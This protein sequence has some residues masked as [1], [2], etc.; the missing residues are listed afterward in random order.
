MGARCSRTDDRDRGFTLVEVIIAMF[1]TLAVLTALIFTLVSTLRV[2]AQAKERQTATAL[3]T[4]VLERM[5]ALPAS[6]VTQVE[7]EVATASYATQVSASVYR[8]QPADLLDGVDEVLI[9]NTAPADVVAS[10][11]P[12]SAQQFDETVEDTTYTIESFVSYPDGVSGATE[13][14]NL[15]A[16]VSWTSRLF[17]EGSTVVQRSTLFTG[18]DCLAGGTSPY[19]APCQGFFTAK[20]GV[21]A[22]GITVSEPFAPP[23]DPTAEDPVTPEAVSLLF[24]GLGSDLSLEQTAAGSSR[25]ASSDAQSVT[26]AVDS[27]PSSEA[28]QSQTVSL[29][30]PGTTTTALGFT[31]TGFGSTGEAR[32]DIQADG[33]DCVSALS[34]GNLTTG[35]ATE[36]RP[37]TSAY[38]Q[39]TSGASLT[40]TVGGTTI[41]LAAIGSGTRDK[42]V[43]GILAAPNP[44]AA[45]VLNAS[46]TC[47]HGAVSR[48]LGTVALATGGSGPVNWD[49]LKGLV[50][51]TGLTET[52]SAEEGVGASPPLYTRAGAL[53]V[54]DGDSYEPIDLSTT[55]DPADPER[56]LSI[57]PTV[58]TYPGSV[59]VTYSGKVTVTPPAAGR[60]GPADCQ[61][62]ACVTDIS[63]TSMVTAALVVT[64]DDGASVS[65]F[66]MAVDLG[67]L[68][69]R[70]SY[71][72]GTDA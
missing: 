1:I 2:I 45:C 72:V 18:G 7:A 70:A 4:Q 16:I 60:S 13:I 24:T 71:K 15:T 41:P 3:A 22:G 68:L 67:G 6:T 51:V 61:T 35:P 30:R 8:L 44:T 57:A 20:A 14:Y 10:G 38:A 36:L 23:S 19:A 29:T 50:S 49:P 17:P 40:Y 48:S 9:V 12:G 42:V 54:W 33:T 5:R 37:C 32:A 31:A 69:A 65:R 63:S 26:A 56:S 43:S 28:S 58:V 46:P 52:A 27:D 59:T 34:A 25:T 55:E 47:G 66:T 64:V 53:E 21:V 62:A 39:R 11:W